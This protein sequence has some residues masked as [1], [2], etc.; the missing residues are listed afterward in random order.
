MCIKCFKGHYCPSRS[1]Q[2]LPCPTGKYSKN[3]GAVTCDACPAGHSC[4]NASDAPKQCKEGEFSIAG[5]VSCKV[6]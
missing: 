2:P 5:V 3:E 1:N 6:S 4:L